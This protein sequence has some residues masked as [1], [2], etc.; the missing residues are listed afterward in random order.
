MLPL[1]FVRQLFPGVGTP[2]P[3]H[4]VTDTMPMA[5]GC[6][7]RVEASCKCS[8]RIG[9]E[10]D[11]KRYVPEPAP[12]AAGRRCAH[13]PDGEPGPAFNR[14]TLPLVAPLPAT[15]DLKRDWVEGRGGTG[16]H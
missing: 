11:E 4:H 12:R 7:S 9:E 8:L 1:A 5:H 14:F 10:S 2:G 3:C 6:P 16:K 15:V 13:N